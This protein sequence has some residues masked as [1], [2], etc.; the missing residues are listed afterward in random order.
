MT[1]PIN[2]IVTEMEPEIIKMTKE[3]QLPLAAG[4]NDEKI[5]EVKI[6]ERLELESKLKSGTSWFYWIAGLSLINS[7]IMLSG[8]DWYF[9]IGLG[10]TQLID[11]VIGSGSAL[12]IDAV[13]AGVLIYFGR[14]AKDGKNWAF[15]VGMVLYGL[16]A[17]LLLV[18]SDY[19]SFVF[20]IL[21]LFGIYGGLQASLKLEKYEQLVL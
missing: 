3:K 20:H 13:V 9:V 16:D 1:F 18:F 19:L 17:V 6:K 5:E 4:M 14:M 8:N 11:A 12:I 15:I 10:I 2:Y 21:A 7:V